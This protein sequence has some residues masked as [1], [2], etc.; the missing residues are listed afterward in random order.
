MGWILM[1]RSVYAVSFSI[2]PA[3]DVEH[4]TLVA[5]AQ[6]RTQRVIIHRCIITLL[7]LIGMALTVSNLRLH[8]RVKLHQWS[9]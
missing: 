1:I 7:L 3:H 5:G 4:G 6:I 2:V 9:V 8:P